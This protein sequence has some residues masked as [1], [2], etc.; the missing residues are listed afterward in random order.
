MDNKGL[1]VFSAFDGLTCGQIA[2]KELVIKVYKYYASEID[3]YA[4]K[5]TMLNFPDTIQLGSVTDVDVSKLD[6]IDLLIGG[7]PCFAAGTKVLTID[8]YKNIEDIVVGDMV[9]THKNRFMP[10]LRV[11][12][13]VENTFTLK[14]QGFIDVVCTKNHPFYARKKCLNITNRSMEEIVDGCFLVSLNGL[15]LEI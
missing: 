2:L 6:K 9:L 13:K 7:S 3:K 12:G 14:A 4:I 11:G 15:K 8:G 1:T 10:V 5:Q